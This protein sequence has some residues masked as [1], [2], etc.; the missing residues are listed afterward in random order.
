MFQQFF[1]LSRAFII[2]KTMIWQYY[3]SEKS[4]TLQAKRISY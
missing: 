2:Y 1:L 4:V 3:L